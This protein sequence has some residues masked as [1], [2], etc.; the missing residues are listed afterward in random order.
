MIGLV[1]MMPFYRHKVAKMDEGERKEPEERY[2][3]ESHD[4]QR[5]SAPVR[6]F[7]PSFTKRARFTSFIFLRPNPPRA[8]GM[9]RE[10]QDFKERFLVFEEE[11]PHQKFLK[12]L[13]NWLQM[14]LGSKKN[15]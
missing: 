8:L 10:F 14:L 2:L 15:L 11:N 1:L 4:T 13:S 7:Q 3:P 5:E 6:S 12:D 9:Q